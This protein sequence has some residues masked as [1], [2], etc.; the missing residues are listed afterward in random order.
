MTLVLSET[1][2]FAV[3]IV[4]LAGNF[5]DIPNSALSI[6]ASYKFSLLVKFIW[7]AMKSQ[8][9]ENNF[10]HGMKMNYSLR[11]RDTNV[12]VVN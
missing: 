3:L 8:H 2:L 9:F 12:Q 6:T 11:Y 4:A 10:N 7:V 5:I 1:T